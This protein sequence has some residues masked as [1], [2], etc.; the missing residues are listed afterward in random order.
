MLNKLAIVKNLRNLFCPRAPSWS[1]AEL[2]FKPRFV[3]ASLPPKKHIHGCPV[4]E[5]KSA[6]QGW[7]SAQKDSSYALGWD[8]GKPNFNQLQSGWQD[9]QIKEQNWRSLASLGEGTTST[10]WFSQDLLLLT[11]PLPHTRCYEDTLVPEFIPGLT[12]RASAT[13]GP[14]GPYGL[15]RWRTVGFLVVWYSSLPV[16]ELAARIGLGIQEQVHFG[17]TVF[18]RLLIENAR[19][20]Q[21]MLERIHSCTVRSFFMG[22]RGDSRGPQNLALTFSDL[23]SNLGLFLPSSRFPL[24]ILRGQTCTTVCF[25]SLSPHCPQEFLP[26]N[27]LHFYGSVYFLK[28]LNWQKQNTYSIILGLNDESC[29]FQVY[30]FHNTVSLVAVK[31]KQKKLN[32]SIT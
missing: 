19:A 2:K 16:H 25:C 13:S 23:H 12:F 15:A 26:G 22:V 10:S 8:M 31:L 24:P 11:P 28:N 27:I 1:G 5:T 3:W 18:A 9:S 21:S 17:S 6:R 7:P 30:N 14:R 29:M 4:E 20:W 32:D